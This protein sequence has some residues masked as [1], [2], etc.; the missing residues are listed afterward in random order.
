MK[1]HPPVI[2]IPPEDPYQKD[3]FARKQFGDSLFSLFSALEESTVLCIDAAWGEGKTTFAQMWM[4][5]LK[6]QGME[7]IYFDAYANDYSDDPFVSF[8]AEIISLSETAFPDCPE[9]QSRKEDFRRRAKRVGA[10]LASVGTRIGVKAVTLGVLKDS[11]IDALESIRQDIANSS[12]AALSSL[13]E[14]A[15]ND[16][17]EWKDGIVEFRKNLSVLGAAV[18][19]RQALPLLIVIDELDRCRP[20]FALSLI[21]RVKHFF[22]APNISFVLLANMEQLQNYVKAV[23][24]SEVDARKY[25]HKFFT[26]STDLPQNRRDTH[27]N[28]HVKYFRKLVEHYEIDDQRDLDPYLVRLF[29]HYAFSLRE[30][31]QCLAILTL[32]F[33]SLPPGRIS[34]NVV[35]SFL[36]MLRLRFPEVFRLLA[37][38]RMSY[39]E[40]IEATGVDRIERAD[41]TNFSKDSFLGILK[42]LLITDEE[43][44]ELDEKD[45]VRFSAQWLNR[46]TIDRLKVMPL[47][48]AELCRFNISIA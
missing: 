36:A 23:Y 8:C 47:F 5:D 15:I 29:Q 24:G 37:E 14:Q 30:M 45:G 9:I 22:S 4:A 13:V 32:Y 38:G 25:L 18:R 43:Y 17:S 7:C 27:D 40:L 19:K 28:D 44:Q 48:C 26:L 31:E 39:A 1:L 21:E 2:E 35:V 42:F 20:D 34:H 33:A 16:H 46:W 3:L 41:Y 10:R 12:S 11:D 6:K